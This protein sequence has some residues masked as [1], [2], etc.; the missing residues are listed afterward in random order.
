MPST[1]ALVFSAAPT[2][3]LPE[4]RAKGRNR[5]I[6]V[7]A[8]EVIGLCKHGQAKFAR[9]IR[10]RG[11]SYQSGYLSVLQRGQPRRL[12]PGDL[13]NGDVSVR[14]KPPLRKDLPCRIV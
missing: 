1:R 6:G 9:Q 8:A 12:A 10:H 11:L 7:G 5:R 2:P 13:N 3:I 4:K 14:P